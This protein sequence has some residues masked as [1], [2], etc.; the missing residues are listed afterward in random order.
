MSGERSLANLL[1]IKGLSFLVM[2]VPLPMG[3]LMNSK[4]SACG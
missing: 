3:A 2:G 1:A 4:R